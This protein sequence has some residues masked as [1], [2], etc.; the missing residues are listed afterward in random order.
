[1]TFNKKLFD[2]E[3]RSNVDMSHKWDFTNNSKIKKLRGTLMLKKLKRKIRKLLNTPI[4]RENNTM[5]N[6]TR[7]NVHTLRSQP[8]LGCPGKIRVR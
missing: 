4:F 5:T 6:S 7:E 8:F 1:M 3:Q 2:C